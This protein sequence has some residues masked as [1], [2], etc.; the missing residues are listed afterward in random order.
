MA[1]VETAAASPHL[2]LILDIDGVHIVPFESRSEGYVRH[3]RFTLSAY[4]PAHGP[5]LNRIYETSADIYYISDSKVLSHWAIGQYLGVPEFDWI[6]TDHYASRRAATRRSL[7]I[8]ALFGDRPL[9]W[10]DDFIR[11]PEMA[12]ARERRDRGIATLA[13]GTDQYIGLQP[14]HMQ[15]IDR[16]FD[17]WEQERSARGIPALPARPERDTD[18]EAR[19]IERADR[20]FAQLTS[21]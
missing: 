4:N 9:V 7:A 10:V 12:W 19:H 13:V 3:P 8:T 14:T 1:Q 15:H 5:W 21:Q 20:W 18:L 11:R 16:W 6:D 17:R 2:A